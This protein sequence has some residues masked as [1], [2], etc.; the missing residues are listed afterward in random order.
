[1]TELTKILGKSYEKLKKNLRRTYEK[2][3]KTYKNRILIV[4]KSKH[5]EM[6]NISPFFDAWRQVS[7]RLSLEDLSDGEIIQTTCFPRSVVE[8]LRDM[9]KNSK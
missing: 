3:M 9:I 2:V 7:K 5:S 6:A 8:E 1:M 4:D